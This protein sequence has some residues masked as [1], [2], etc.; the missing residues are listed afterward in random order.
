VGVLSE[1][2]HASPL[3]GQVGGFAA[4]SFRSLF[5]CGP[6]PAALKRTSLF[7]PVIEIG[8]M[9]G[10]ACAAGPFGLFGGRIA[11]IFENHPDIGQITGRRVG[12]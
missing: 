4:L 5:I 6:H 9:I 3:A 10:S 11:V 8:A 2:H 7:L 12:S 1:Q